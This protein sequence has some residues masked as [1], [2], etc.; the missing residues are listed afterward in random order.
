MIQQL[1]ISLQEGQKVTKTK[2][3]HTEERK[4]EVISNESA[5]VQ[6]Q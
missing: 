1:R 6:Q 4:I 3:R 5:Q 2:M